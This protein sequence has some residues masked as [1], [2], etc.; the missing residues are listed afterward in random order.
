MV[1]KPRALSSAQ[2]SHNGQLFFPEGPGGGRRPRPSPRGA[3]PGPQSTP[4]SRRPKLGQNWGGPGGAF[5]LFPGS[6]R[7]VPRIKSD[8]GEVRGGGAQRNASIDEICSGTQKSLPSSLVSRPRLPPR[9][10]DPHT[11]LK[12]GHGAG[13]NAHVPKTCPPTQ[14]GR[15]AARRLLSAASVFRPLRSTPCASENPALSF[16]K[17]GARV[18]LRLAHGLLRESERAAP[19]PALFRVLPKYPETPPPD[20]GGWGRGGGRG[21]QLAYLFV[22]ERGNPRLPLVELLLEVAVLWKHGAVGS[23]W[24]PWGSGAPGAPRTLAPR[25][26]ARPPATRPKFPGLVPH[27]RRPSGA[28]RDRLPVAAASSGQLAGRGGSRG[29]PEVRPEPCNF[30]GRGACGVSVSVCRGRGEEQRAK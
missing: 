12:W 2:L 25:P 24:P 16:Q 27:A 28:V 5:L 1:L 29:H 21:L 26:A 22:A 23:G 4:D 3:S 20:P 6:W 13:R 19:W 10:P 14:N 17:S 8:A 9:Y 11:S 7:Q 18:T 15:R 30:A